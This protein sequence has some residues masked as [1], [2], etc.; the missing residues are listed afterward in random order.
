MKKPATSRTGWWIAGLLE[1]HS[2]TDRPTYWN[3]YR[4]IKAG[5]WRTAFR[6]AAELGAANAR[7]GNKAFSGHQEFI[8]V[9]DLLP[10]Y[11]EFEDGAELLWQ[12][13]EASQ[14]DDGIPLRVFT[15]TDLESQYELPG[16]DGVPANA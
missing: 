12:E 7:V 11:D 1:K 15:V 14:D 6:K 2:N 4:L 8:G 5:D 3:N 13:L 9:T 10:I 16:D